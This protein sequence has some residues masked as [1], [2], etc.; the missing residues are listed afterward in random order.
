M[1]RLCV[2]CEG[3]TESDFV[4]SCLQQD[5]WGHG[6]SVYPSTLKTKPGKQ[7][8][9]DVTLERLAKH[10][11][12]EYPNADYI[13]TFVDYY[14]FR[15]RGDRTVEQL[16]AAILAAALEQRPEAE[17]RRILPYVQCHEFEALLFSNINE[18]RWVLDGWNQTTQAA[19]AKIAARFPNPED[20]NDSP[21]TA[22]SKRLEAL[23]AHAYSKREHGPLIAEEIGLVT[24]RQHC[25]RFNR[26]LD[27]LAALS[28]S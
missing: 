1:I 14:G 19:L 13:T 8:G 12:N 25:P 11:R 2:I 9:G 24:I 7:G 4:R 3:Q 18:F 16:E 21:T 27:R 23:F 17:D 5:L 15:K 28:S 22:P 20:I 26:W 10:I 6:V